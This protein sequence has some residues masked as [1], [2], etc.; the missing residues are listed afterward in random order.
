MNHP[1]Y[2]NARRTPM[3][4]W[5]RLRNA[6]DIAD[7]T[8]GVKRRRLRRFVELASQ[9]GHQHLDD[10]GLRIEIIAP[11]ALQ[12]HRL[13]HRPSDVPHEILEQRELTGLE[14]DATTAAGDVSREEIDDEIAG[15]QARGRRDLA[16]APQQRLNAGQQLGKRKGLR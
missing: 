14:I 3:V 10:V 8:N 15:R 16:G 4:L 2:Q 1:A 6:K 7:A 9:A 12:D 11:Y 5:A 13:R